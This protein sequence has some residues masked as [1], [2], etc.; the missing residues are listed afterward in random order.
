[1]KGHLGGH[2]SVCHTPS[3][4]PG[5]LLVGLGLPHSD[6]SWSPHSLDTLLSSSVLPQV[7]LCCGLCSWVPK[8][9][10]CVL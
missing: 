1:M 2:P 3:P 10:S 4:C 8:G 6:P 9:D 5:P 7:S